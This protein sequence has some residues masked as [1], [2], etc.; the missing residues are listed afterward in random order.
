MKNKLI[1]VLLL[2]AIGVDAHMPQFNNNKP[3][4]VVKA[5]IQFG[6]ENNVCKAI[7]DWILND[8]LSPIQGQSVQLLSFKMGYQT[9]HFLFNHLYLGLPIYGSTI[10]VNITND[11]HLLQ[12]FSNLVKMNR[13]QETSWLQANC[14]FSKANE[15]QPAFVYK[16]INENGLWEEI[17]KDA[18]GNI[19]A[20]CVLDLL[21]K[22]DT[23]V[24]SKLFAPDP[25]ST[26][27]KS[28]G[29]D[30]GLWTNKNGNDYNEINAQRVPLALPLR[31]ENDTFYAENKHVLIVDLETPTIAPFKSTQNSFDFTRAQAPFRE[32]MAL[33]HIANL[34]AYLRSIQ[35]DSFANFQ[36]LVDAHAYQGRD[37]SR[38]SLT[39]ADKPALFFGT[40]GV[41]D[42]EDADVIIHEYTHGINHSITPNTTS[43]S[44]RMALEEANCDFMACQYSKSY[45]EYNWRQVFNW[46]GHNEYWDG[47]NAASNKKYPKDVS[48]NFYSTSELW[49]SMM[50]DLSLDLGREI[51]TKILFY[52]MYNYAA[53]M[54]LQD[55]ADLLVQTDSLLYNKA[56]F[57][58]IK[59][60]LIERGFAVSIA[61]PE[62]QVLKDAIRL[63]NT[64]E[65]ANGVGNISILQNESAPIKLSVYSINGAFIK[66]TEWLTQPE[67]N[68][69]EFAAGIYLIKVQSKTSAYTEK[70]MKLN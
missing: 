1:I 61:I 65:F 14:W 38:F 17:V 12:A 62:Q 42:A 30:N 37:Q 28:Y 36:I 5:N 24:Q 69:A 67:L 25:L 27:Q 13:P 46:D 54:G 10:K 41:P 22:Q 21:N 55:A 40:G 35:I 34:Q 2:L 26:A 68:P 19:L 63:V 59:Q 60:R 58:P 3:C 44:E 31:Y 8:Q 15:L 43:G 33:S 49:S 56:H 64:Q 4:T 20:N 45:T 47:R 9:K 18:S 16:D 29:A 7:E 66:E 53:G 6:I 23:L 32:Y 48:S 50:N 57:W 11:G 51:A 70:V 52:S 39:G